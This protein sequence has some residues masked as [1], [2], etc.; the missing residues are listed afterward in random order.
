MAERFLPSVIEFAK[1]Q[2]VAMRRRSLSGSTIALLIQSF[3]RSLFSRL[4]DLLSRS[5]FSRLILQRAPRGRD[6]EIAPTGNFFRELLSRSL[7]GHLI[8]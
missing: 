7:T 8:V 5:L 4:R 2:G 3:D 1:R 6:S